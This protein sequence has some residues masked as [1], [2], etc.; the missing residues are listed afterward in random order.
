MTRT[1]GAAAVTTKFLF[2]ASSCLRAIVVP[3]GLLT[4]VIW[5]TGCVDRARVNGDCKWIHEA[6]PS[7]LDMGARANREHLDDDALFA[8]DL[9]IRHADAQRGHRSAWRRRSPS[10]VGLRADCGRRRSR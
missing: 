2:R 8:E 5:F 6:R 3:A 9:A 4:S 1:A 7:A 10:R